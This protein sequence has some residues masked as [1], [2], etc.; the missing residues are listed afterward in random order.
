MSYILKLRVK[1]K[2]GGKTEAGELGL[3]VTSTKNPLPCGASARWQSEAAR[4][5]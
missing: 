2:F 1:E 4:E 3:P 5:N